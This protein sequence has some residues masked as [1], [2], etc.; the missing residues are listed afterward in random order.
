MP[1][2]S[3]AVQSPAATSADQ[4]RESTDFMQFLFDLLH[5]CPTRMSFFSWFNVGPVQ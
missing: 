2:A 4:Q 1:S 3:G 5:C